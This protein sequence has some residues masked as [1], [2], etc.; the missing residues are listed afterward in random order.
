MRQTFEYRED[1]TL[2]IP[3]AEYLIA[4]GYG[5]RREWNAA[6]HDLPKFIER[7]MDRLIRSTG[8]KH[9][10]DAPTLD[11]HFSDSKGW[12]DAPLGS[13]L[14]LVLEVDQC[15][16]FRMGSAIAALESEC[17]GLG[18]AFYMVFTKSIH[19]LCWAYD[20]QNASC[21]A[22]YQMEAIAEEAGVGC[23][24]DLTKEQRAQYQLPDPDAAVPTAILKWVKAGKVPRGAMQLLAGHKDGCNRRLIQPV[25]TL[26][27]LAPAYRK[28]RADLPDDGVLPSFAVFFRDHDDIAGSFDDYGE[29]AMEADGPQVF[30]KAFN[31]AK[32]AAISRA[33]DSFV[34]AVKM[35]AAAAQLA[36][37]VNGAKQ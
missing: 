20:Y 18:A 2:L 23:F 29:T 25:L 1:A 9:T 26:A 6:A 11:A 7:G 3:V 35:Y 15:G 21:S 37:A 12:T 5:T 24:A 14:R 32:P 10:P 8:Y 22:D 30:I 13:T 34:L 27:A 4:S 36:T 16:W 17:V 28:N 31:P 33:F 19:A